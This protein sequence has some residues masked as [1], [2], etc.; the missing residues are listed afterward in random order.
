[1]RG[2]ELVLDA[3]LKIYPNADLF[4]LIHNKGTLNERIENRQIFT[5]FTDRLPFKKTKYRS[6]LPLFPMAIESFDL[7]GYDLVISSSHCVA[8]G[9]IPETDSFHISY[10]HTPMRYIWDL[11]YDYFPSKKGL[12]SFVLQFFSTYLRTWDTSSSHR[13]DKFVSNSQY[14]SRRI[15]RYYGRESV[16]IYPP[17]LPPNFVAEEAQK[18]DFYLVVSAL[19][20]YK[21]I[22]LAIEAFKLSG[23]KLVVIG[24]G[25][26]EKKL[27][28]NVSKNIIFLSHL[29]RNDIIDYYRRARGFIF[30]GI[31][32]FGITPVEAQGYCTPIVAFRKGGALETV[33]ENKTG[34]FFDN[35]TPESLNEAIER[36][37]KLNFQ[38][39][40]FQENINRFSEEIF[41]KEFKNQVDTSYR[42]FSGKG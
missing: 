18:E 10:I 11:F 42:S 12:K 17:C 14:I 29:S 21:R 28:K 25:Q 24:G 32:D 3:L 41:I 36:L 9:V 30:P 15:R 19:A 23:K 22:D 27:K 31:E 26:D 6:Y 7:R 5:A 40:H 8:K 38:K 13:V 1:M 37:E 4:T 20:P 16:V 39:K 34:V 33:V 35:Q 2:G